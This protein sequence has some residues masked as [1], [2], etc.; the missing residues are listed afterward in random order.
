MEAV[1]GGKH[2]WTARDRT[3]ITKM[4]HSLD[5]CE[6]LEVFIE[7]LEYDLLGPDE[8]DVDIKHIALKAREEQ[9]QC[10]RQC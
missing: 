2:R 10:W 4:K 6:S 1:V 9:Q 7:E 5:R 8:I 3:V